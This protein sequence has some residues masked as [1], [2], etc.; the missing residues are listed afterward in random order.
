[1]DLVGE[2]VTAESMV[3]SNPDLKD[4]HLENFTKAARELRKLTDELQ[5]VVMSMRMV[6]LSGVFQKMNRIVRDMCKKLGKEA[7]LVTIGAETEVDKS[8]NDSITDPF[9]HMVRNSI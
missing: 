9:M 4:L 3:A 5:D 6:P 1:M 8:I 7:D 2:I